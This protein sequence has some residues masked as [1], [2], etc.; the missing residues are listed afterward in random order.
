VV[1]LRAGDTRFP[2][3]RFTLRVSCIAVSN[4]GE[5]PAQKVKAVYYCTV[6]TVP[7]GTLHCITREYPGITTE[8]LRSPER[9]V[10]RVKSPFLINT[11]V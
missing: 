6:P 1:F 2:S 9:I 11:T 5:L 3:E 4:H 8:E 7:M 10:V